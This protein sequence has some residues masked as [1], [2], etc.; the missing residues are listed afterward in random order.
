MLLC[1]LL[2]N[3]AYCWLNNYFLYFMQGKYGNHKVIFKLRIW[4]PYTYNMLKI[5]I[6]VGKVCYWVSKHKWIKELIWTKVGLLYVVILV[7]SLGGTKHINTGS[8]FSCV[9]S[10][11]KLSQLN[12]FKLF[13]LVLK[14]S[15]KSNQTK[16]LVFSLVV[17]RAFRIKIKLKRVY[18]SCDYYKNLSWFY[19]TRA[20][21]TFCSWSRLTMFMRTRPNL[22]CWMNLLNV[23]RYVLRGSAE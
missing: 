8:I 17:W 20:R 11:Q 14:K 22:A 16:T 1:Y 23:E 10:C 5:D 19:F 18:L 21:H 9:L 6:E 15:T 3:F 12:Q 7:C 13:C 4:R 2:F